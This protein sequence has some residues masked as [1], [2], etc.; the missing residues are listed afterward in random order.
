MSGLLPPADDTA[1]LGPADDTAGLGPADDTAGLTVRLARPEDAELVR[2]VIVEAFLARPPLDPPSTAPEE[3]VETVRDAITSCGGV[4]AE[5]DGGV[6]GV[7]L[8]AHEAD[9]LTL[10]RVATRPA[11][12]RR[13][14]A[15][16]MAAFAERHAAAL[17]ARVVTCAART[18]LPDT[19]AFWRHRGYVEAGHRGHLVDLAKPAPA[20]LRLP[21]A[22]DTRGLGLRLAGLV[23]AG[24]LVVLSGDLGAG[25][26]TLTQGIGAG[27]GVRGQVTSPTFVIARVHPGPGP[28][29]VHVDAYRLGGSLEIDDLDLDASIE[30]SVTV[31]E[32]GAGK[33]ERLTA[34][35]LE[36]ELVQQPDGS[37]RTAVLRGVGRAWLERADALAALAGSSG[38]PGSPGPATPVGPGGPAGLAPLA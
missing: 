29:L 19:V 7:L 6:A 1:G 25:K 22:E 30:E 2:E 3:T 35:R 26:T 16:A 18:E 17:R 21:S 11:Y 36:V 5:Q 31:V 20:V 14:V 10:R 38:S 33:V 24:D 12:R 9:V 37:T 27:L 28:D 13:G 34:D 8:M 23:R 4:L 32:W 15:T